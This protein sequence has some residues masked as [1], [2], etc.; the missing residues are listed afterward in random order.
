MPR[1][2]SV[3]LIGGLA[4][5]SAFSQDRVRE[6]FEWGE[7]DSL[8]VALGHH[9]AASPDAAD[10]ARPCRYYGY[11]GVAYFAK[12]DIA[13]ARRQFESALRCDPALSLDTQYVTPEMLNLFSATKTEQEERLQHDRAQDSLRALNEADLAAKETKKRQAAAFRSAYRK[14]I[15]GGTAGASLCLGM[16]WLAIHEYVAGQEDDRNFKA[17]AAGGDRAAYDHYGELLKRKNGYIIGFTA[18]SA[19]GGCAGAYFFFRGMRLGRIR[20]SLGNAGGEYAIA[21]ATPF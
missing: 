4:A 1:I 9:F 12:G 14:Q 2:A 3:I 15:A 5:C 18:A 16:G 17:A 10:S 20:V 21:V 6:F 13:E 7:Y 11:G 19:A 8:I